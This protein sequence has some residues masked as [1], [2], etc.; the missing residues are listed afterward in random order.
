M[1][2]K[3]VAYGKFV[4][5]FWKRPKLAKDVLKLGIKLELARRRVVAN[6]KNDFASWVDLTALSIVSSAF[7]G[8]RIALVNLFFPVEIMAGFDLK[9]VSAEGL[10]GML[11]AMHLEDLALNRAEAMGISKNTCSFHRAGLGLNLLKMVSNAKVVA[12]TNV[13]CDG[14]V[15]IFKTIA[16]IHGLDPLIV[17]VPRTFDQ[18][19]VHSVSQQLEG[20]VHELENELNQSFNYSKFE[21]QLKIESEIFGTLRELYP[22]LCENPVGLHLYQHVNLLYALHVRPDV[23]M[24]KAVRALRKQ[25]DSNVPTFKKRFLW[26]HLSPYYDN[27]LNDIFSKDSQYS[28]VASELSWDWLNWKIDVAHPFKCLAEKILSNPLLGDVETRA[29]FALQLALDFKVDGVIHFNHFGCKQ[30]SGS[31]EILKNAFDEV[32]IP[33]LSLDGDC[34]DHTSAS[35]EQYKT[36]IQAFLE[37]IG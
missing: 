13:L 35:S 21:E 12:A 7:E 14:N 24:L 10:A 18:S 23:H 20:I 26:M 2:K 4:R 22:K 11:A 37:M 1:S 25:L 32:R 17:D 31:V 3:S 27:V 33:F 6:I 19:S 15:P 29:K 28:V 9:C 5:Y 30:S 36:R 16:Q 34:V 8:G